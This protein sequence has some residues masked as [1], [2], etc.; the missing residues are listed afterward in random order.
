M[1]GDQCD[2]TISHTTGTNLCR[3]KCSESGGDLNKQI[4][5]LM[6]LSDSQVETENY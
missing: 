1:S 3:N 4:H 5:T 2:V 6:V